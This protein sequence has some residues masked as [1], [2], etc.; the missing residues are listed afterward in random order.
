MQPFRMKC[1]CRRRR[2]RAMTLIELLVVVAALLILT[3]ISTA[4]MQPVL[5]S[6]KIREAARQLNA[7]IAGSVARAAA[8]LPV[9]N[10]FVAPMLPEPILRRSPRPR[11]RLSRMPKGIEPRR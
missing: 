3:A 5:K 2:R 6:R 7:Y 8:L 9:R 11:V 10:T 1:G 4:M